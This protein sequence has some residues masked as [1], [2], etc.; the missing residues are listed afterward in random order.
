MSRLPYAEIVRQAQAECSS[1]EARRTPTT[2][3]QSYAARIKNFL[4]FLQEHKRPGN[5]TG[6]DFIGYKTVVTALVARG[7]FKESALEVFGSAL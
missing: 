5:V 1:A 7:E 4:F 6:D 3:G 2:N